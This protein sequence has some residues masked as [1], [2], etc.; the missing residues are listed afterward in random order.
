VTQRSN[1]KGKSIWART[2]AFLAA[3]AFVLQTVL[4]PIAA[5]A[6]TTT[7][8][9]DTASIL[10]CAEHGQALDQNQPVIPHDH[11]AICKFC[12]ACPANALLAP[13]ALASAA[14]IAFSITPIH[15]QAAARF[16]SDRDFPAFKQARGP[17]TSA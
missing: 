16:V 1:T 7:V 14:A 17:P 4:A 15:W 5:A 6:A 11:E 10:L 8:P 12:I 13:D 2:V 3:Y 9:T